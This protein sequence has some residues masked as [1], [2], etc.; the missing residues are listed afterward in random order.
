MMTKIAFPT[1]DGRNISR[2]FGQAAQFL[3]LTVEDGQVVARESRLKPAHSHDHGHD[4]SHEPAAQ[5]SLGEINVA[6]G[7]GGHDGHQGMFDLLADCQVLM[8]GGMG[9]PAYDRAAAMGLEVVLPGEKDI[10]KALE[11][12]LAGTLRSDMRRVHEHGAGHQH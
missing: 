1:D 11:A 8:A 4:H 6:Q 10:E 9:Q 12:Y 7:Q 3:V 2:H 5:V